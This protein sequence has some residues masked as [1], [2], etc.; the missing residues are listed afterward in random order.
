MITVLV[1]EFASGGGFSGE[2]P[3]G[4]LGEGRAMRDAVCLD[5]AELGAI[6]VLAATLLHELPPPGSRGVS[7]SFGESANAFLRRVATTVDAVWLIAP[8]SN[9]ISLELT[10][11]LEDLGTNI[12]GCGSAAVALASSKSLTLERLAAAGFATIPTWPLATA[13]LA[14]YE[15]W[16]VKPDRGCGC[17]D[18]RRLPRHAVNPLYQP[19]YEPHCQR[20]AESIIAQPWLNGDAMSLSLLVN[21]PDVEILSINRQHIAEAEDGSLALTGITRCV[22]IDTTTQDRLEALSVGLVAAIPGLRGYVGVDFVLDACATPMVLEVNPRLTSA[23][24]GL[25]AML[26]RN[27][28]EDILRATMTEAAAYA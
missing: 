12:I 11:V 7:P 4:I 22:V 15:T 21:G 9:G 14:L 20:E 3:L 19:L 8:E 2:A 27:L 5:L 16:V 17:E 28:A 1:Y 23:Y 25:S 10:F 24:V 13:P 6:Q 26:G 18:M